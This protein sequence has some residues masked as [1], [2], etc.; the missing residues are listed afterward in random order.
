MSDCEV[1]TTTITKHRTRAPVVTHQEINLRIFQRQPVPRVLF[2]PRIEPWFAWHEA[3]GMLPKSCRDRDVAQVYDDLG[4]SRRY[5]AHFSGLAEP[6]EW[7]YDPCI[8]VTDHV[9]SDEK[10]TVFQ[11][12][13]GE[14]VEKRIMTVDRVWR[15]VNFAVQSADDLDTLECLYDNTAAWFDEEKFRIGQQYMHESGVP[16]F[17]ITSSP[18]ETITQDWMHFE[19]FIYAMVDMPDR[20]ERVMAAIDRAQDTMFA[21]LTACDGVQIVNF[22][23]NIHVGRMSPDYFERHL[24]PWYDKRATQ[25]RDAGIFTHIHIDGDFQPLL[26]YLADLPFDGLEALTPLPQGDVTLEQIRDHIGDRILLDGIPAVLFLNEHSRDELQECVG[27][28]VD[29][30]HPRLVLGISDELPQGGDD[31]SFERVR[32]V[33]DFCRGKMV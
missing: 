21:Q 22:P 6:V 23:E 7:R 17:W 19:D 25:L 18:Y 32:W 14:L 30:F 29:Y 28:L 3:F 8:Q 5:F 33:A 20:M 4:A 9:E 26:P 24:M 1:V 11:T 10:T 12:P 27:K 13:R 15:K 16:Q 31:E 2:Q